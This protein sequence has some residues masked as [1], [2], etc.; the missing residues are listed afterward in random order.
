MLVDLAWNRKIRSFEVLAI[1]KF[2]V[3]EAW[4]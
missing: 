1:R 2:E 4:L 3:L